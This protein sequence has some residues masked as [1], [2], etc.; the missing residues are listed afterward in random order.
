MTLESQQIPSHVGYALVFLYTD[1]PYP[2]TDRYIRVKVISLMPPTRSHCLLYQH[3]ICKDSLL[4]LHHS[5][6]AYMTSPLASSHTLTLGIKVQLTISL[7][8]Y[9]FF[10]F[11]V[12]RSVHHTDTSYSCITYFPKNIV[13]HFKT[14]LHLD[15]LLH[16]S[17]SLSLLCHIANNLSP[18]S[19]SVHSCI[20]SHRDIS[21]SIA[22][23]SWINVSH[24]TSVALYHILLL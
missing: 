13:S 5:N 12:D 3:S 10:L 11:Q 16:S 15:Y 8:W 22:R 14:P 4:P 1:S 23:L 19:P 21:P 9:Q 17:I 24:L 20:H 7:S 18:L 6:N 2:S